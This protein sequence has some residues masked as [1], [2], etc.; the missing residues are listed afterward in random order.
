MKQRGKISPDLRYTDMTSKPT[1]PLKSTDVARMVV[2]LCKKEFPSL[3]EVLSGTL[4][5]RIVFVA[6]LI[7]I[8]RGVRLVDE[9]PTWIRSGYI[10]PNVFLLFLQAKENG[11]KVSA[12][13]IV[14]DDERDNELL[15]DILR[16]TL[17]IVE[18]FQSQTT[19]LATLLI[20]V[21]KTCPH[22][23][24]TKV[25]VDWLENTFKYPVYPTLPDDDLYEFARSC[26]LLADSKD[27]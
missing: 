25:L 23:Y 5:N 26:V 16:T 21:Q 19:N 8:G 22:W 1:F 3:W 12:S 15:L 17:G 2:Y 13:R 4:V 14:L 24:K 18:K 7:A 11:V 27:D 6:S 20:N 9:S 10:Y